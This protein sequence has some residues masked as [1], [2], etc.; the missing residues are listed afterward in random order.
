MI[1]KKIFAVLV[2]VG[3]LAFGFANVSDMA[4]DTPDA[5]PIL[6]VHQN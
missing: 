2:L 4:V 1:M 3:A 6:S 5:L